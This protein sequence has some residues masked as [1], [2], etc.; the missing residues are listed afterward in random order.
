MKKTGLDSVYC[1]IHQVLKFLDQSDIYNLKS[2]Y[3]HL[4]DWW[5][6][7]LVDETYHLF[8]KERIELKL[9]PQSA[10]IQHIEILKHDLGKFIYCFKYIRNFNVQG[11]ATES[12]SKRLNEILSLMPRLQKLEYGHLNTLTYKI[13]CH[14]LF[15]LRS[16]F[17][18]YT[19]P[20]ESSLFSDLEHKCFTKLVELRL[21]TRDRW[22]SKSKGKHISLPGTLKDIKISI[23]GIKIVI[24]KIPVKLFIDRANFV[25]IKSERNRHFKELTLHMREEDSK[26]TSHFLNHTFDYKFYY[27]VLLETQNLTNNLVILSLENVTMHREENIDFNQLEVLRLT[28]IYTLQYLAVYTNKVLNYLEVHFC[29]PSL[30]MKLFKK[31]HGPITKEYSLPSRYTV[32]I[33]LCEDELKSTQLLQEDAY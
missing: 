2:C 23:A 19:V 3:Q 22:C 10:Y 24:E 11:N 13:I 27:R 25:G 26:P 12:T 6:L 33:H 4:D 8:I 7:P 31:R 9:H 14:K 17:I 29:S 15:K 18:D 28:K 1:F 20:F 21:T 30:N 5:I 16:L 32:I